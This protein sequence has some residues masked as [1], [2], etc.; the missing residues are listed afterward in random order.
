MGYA[1][2]PK[3]FFLPYARP[4]FKI[5]KFNIPVFPSYFTTLLRSARSA[6]LVRG[7]N[8]GPHGSRGFRPSS[9]G[10]RRSGP[11]RG[12]RSR[13]C[14]S[15]RPGPPGPCPKQHLVDQSL[16]SHRSMLRTNPSTTQ[17][18]FLP[19]HVIHIHSLQSYR[20]EMYM[21]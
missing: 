17:T 14:P 8:C 20:R 13:W 11:R 16:R 7:L 9:P 19:C 2:T 6:M 10:C 21:E 5:K 3:L 1:P 12:I 4:T 15:C 18:H